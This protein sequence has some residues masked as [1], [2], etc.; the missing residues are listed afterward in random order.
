MSEDCPLRLWLDRHEESVAEFCA[1]V[2]EQRPPGIGHAVLYKIMSGAKRV[3]TVPTLE[4][5]EFGTGGEVTYRQM[6]EWL[7]TRRESA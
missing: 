4:M 6:V 7:N 3:I 5:I 2:R 1:R